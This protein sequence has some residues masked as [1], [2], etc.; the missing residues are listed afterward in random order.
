MYI[1]CADLEGVFVPEVWIG[2]AEHT[3]IEALRVTTLEEPDYDKLMMSRIDILNRHNIRLQDIRNAIRSIKAFDGAREFLWWVRKR[4]QV[5]I[6]SD[7]FAQYA[8]PLLEQLD[9]PTILCHNLIVDE[10]G[11]ING[12]KLRQAN[13]K[14]KVVVALQSLEYKVIA[15]GDSYNDTGMLLQADAG[16]LYNAPG[17]VTAEFPQLPVCRNYNELKTILLNYI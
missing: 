7:T 13:P 2:L 11:R 3:G 16:I 9:H 12:Y 15:F 6:V 17:N 14:K 4:S 5:I 1:V 10:A 8:G